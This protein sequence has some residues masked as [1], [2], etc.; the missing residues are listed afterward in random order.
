MAG[1]SAVGERRAPPGDLLPYALAIKQRVAE[2]AVR[3]VGQLTELMGAGGLRLGAPME[4]LVR[5]VQAARFHSPTP[6]V[7]NQILGRS[8]LG[9]ELRVELHDDDETK[10]GSATDRILP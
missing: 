3:G 2:L 8:A 6:L 7:E 10:A 5:D 1:A 4:R 9:G